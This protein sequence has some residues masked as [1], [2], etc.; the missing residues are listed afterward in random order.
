MRANLDKETFSPHLYA[1]VHTL[2]AETRWDIVAP[3][4]VSTP[5]TIL[6][7]VG[8][9]RRTIAAAWLYITV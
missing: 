9:K 5:S 1:L 4:A 3:G 8:S 2:L 6:S 7:P